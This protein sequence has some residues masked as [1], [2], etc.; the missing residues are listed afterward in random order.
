[1]CYPGST[2]AKIV[3]EC[4][5]LMEKQLK[6]PAESAE[7]SAQESPFLMGKKLKWPAEESAEESLFF[8]EKELKWPKMCR[9]RSRRR[10]HLFLWCY[11]VSSQVG[12]TFYQVAEWSHSLTFGVV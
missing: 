9:Q 11:K 1:M 5:S 4:N 3:E 10:G 12:G 7:E 2:P 6:W 8:V